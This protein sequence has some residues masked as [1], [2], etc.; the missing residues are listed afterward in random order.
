MKERI[1]KL[2]LAR[3]LAQSRHQAQALILTGS[4]LADEQR[5]DKPGTRVDSTSRLR[6]KSEARIYVSRGGLKLE[7]ALKH[8]SIEV[9]GK[10][11]LDIGASTGGFTDC[12]LRQGAARIHA[13]DV[14][15]NQLDW[16]LRKDGRVHSLEGVNARYLTFETI[17]EAVDL[18]TLDLSF[19][20]LR[21]VLP[22]LDVFSKPT[23]RIL[24]LI[25]P[26]FEL[27]KGQVEK[28][29]IVRDPQK[30]RLAIDIVSACA[31]DLGYRLLGTVPSPILGAEG[32]R[33]FFLVLGSITP[34][35]C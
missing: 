28:G 32:N 2:L 26:Q 4:V 10:T 34:A 12:L 15:H 31:R 19:I 16:K 6:L 29:G 33:E 27:G 14:G 25:K 5:I 11:C 17:G 8:F 3:G 23:T 24:C 9:G 7:H 35:T 30:H 1:D 21:L 18:I 13:V 20:S 22:V